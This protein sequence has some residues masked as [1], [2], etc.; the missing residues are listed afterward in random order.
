MAGGANTAAVVK[1]QFR[2]VDKNGDGTLSPE[3]FKVL[4]KTLDKRWSDTKLNKLFDKA[5]TDRSGSIDVDEFLNWVFKNKTGQAVA[6]A[7]EKQQQSPAPSR[8]RGVVSRRSSDSA[9]AKRRDASEPASSRRSVRDAAAELRLDEDDG[10][11][12]GSEPARSVSMSPSR[13]GSKSMVKPSVQVISL[14]AMY[15]SLTVHDGI[16]G[17]RLQLNDLAKLF[18]KCRHA[19][20]DSRLVRLVPQEIVSAGMAGG[21]E[22][23]DIS[24][25]EVGH[26]CNLV[27][28]NPEATV[29]DALAK[30]AEVHAS[31]RD[32]E[33]T[34]L[35]TVGL[36]GTVCVGF[37]LFSQV[38]QLLADVMLIDLDTVVATLFWAH[39][40]DFELPE[41]IAGEVVARVFKKAAVGRKGVLEQQIKTDDFVGFCQAQQLVD[42]TGKQGIRD[43][44]A[45]F[46]TVLRKL[47]DLMDKRAARKNSM[48]KRRAPS[49]TMAKKRE[50]PGGM[51]GRAQ[52]SILFEELFLALPRGLYRA[53]LDLVLTCLEVGDAVGV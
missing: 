30:V 3:E 29:E 16:V 31:C 27:K 20:L 2:H 14:A 11:A 28:S 45:L 37:G 42:R 10:G 52:L 5:D 15:E 34:S 24:A 33:F 40:D 9:P 35:K 39:I 51:A 44:G 18:A 41:T 23:E 12:S 13:S 46:T 50:V 7:A 25:Y 6:A 53:P 38:L 4:F 19:G 49:K 17:A 43:P 48:S 47:P 21:R 1:E 22:P 26:L 8:G 36:D 32:L